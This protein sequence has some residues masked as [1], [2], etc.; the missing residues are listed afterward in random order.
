M[1]FQR[2]LVRWF[3]ISV[4]SMFSSRFSIA[5]SLTRICFSTYLASSAGNL[6]IGI[7]EGHVES[8]LV[9]RIF[10]GVGECIGISLF[11]A[12]FSR[13]NIGGKSLLEYRGLV[14]SSI[15]NLSS[16]VL[17]DALVYIYKS[18]KV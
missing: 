14:E 1:F 3:L 17:F 11:L 10:G 6:G 13:F 5:S 12:I 2:Q 18:E 8:S 9:S 4:F 15:P 7:G 16:D